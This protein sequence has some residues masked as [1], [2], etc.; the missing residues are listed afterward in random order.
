MS[1]III[2]DPLK[3]R[4]QQHQL[5]QQIQFERAV[6]G[7][8][9]AA[10]RSI[11]P[12]ESGIDVSRVTWPA[13]RKPEE[14]AEYDFAHHKHTMELAVYIAEGMPEL[15]P[16]DIRVIR[17]AAMLHDLGRERHWKLDDPGHA[18]RSAKLAADVL[19]A[20]PL[21]GQRDLIDDICRLIQEHSL[22]HISY[23]QNDA[24]GAPPMSPLH[25]ALHDAECFESARL[26]PNTLEGAAVMKARMGAV[27]TQWAKNP[28]HQRRWRDRYWK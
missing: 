22:A 14:L 5:A 15:K 8:R 28:E 17:S 26:A 11:T 3:K 10:Q 20:S 21:W 19:L 1:N 12:E 7:S 24:R 9:A 27:L 16:R 18:Q 13:E 6:A 2:N 23:G 4:T 25:V